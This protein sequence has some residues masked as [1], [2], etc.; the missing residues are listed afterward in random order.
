VNNSRILLNHPRQDYY[1][2]IVLLETLLLVCQSAIYL[3][4]PLTCFRM[5]PIK[6]SSG[7]L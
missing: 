5:R 7:G 6:A 4:M 3:K 1:V 2:I